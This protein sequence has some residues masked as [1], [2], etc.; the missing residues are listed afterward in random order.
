MAKEMGTNRSGNDLKNKFNAMER[1]VQG[2]EQRNKSFSADEL[3]GPA[4]ALIAYIT[5]LNAAERAGGSPSQQLLRRRRQPHTASEDSDSG[6]NSEE[7]TPTP[8]PRALRPRRQQWRAVAEPAVQADQLDKDETPSLIEDLYRQ[9]AELGYPD[10]NVDAN[11]TTFNYSMSELELL[12]FCP[13]DW[14]LCD[15]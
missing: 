11:T 2:M 13:D 14:L 6:C 1:R 4:A 10:T 15:F 12:E 7:F 5:E 3:E 9:L 8:P